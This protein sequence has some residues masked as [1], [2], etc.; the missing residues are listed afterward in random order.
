MEHA[1]GAAQLYCHQ[2]LEDSFSIAGG[3]R[4]PHRSADFSDYFE[5]TP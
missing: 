4:I 1:L 3:Q 5:G 2:A